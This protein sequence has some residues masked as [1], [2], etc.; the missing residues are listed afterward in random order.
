LFA[1]AAIAISAGAAL[2]AA[3]ASASAKAASASAT[4]LPMVLTPGSRQ[5]FA[6][7]PAEIDYTGDGTGVLGGFDGTGRYPSYGHLKWSSWTGTEALGSGAVWIDD[8]TPSCAAG[9]FS[10]YAIAVRAFD[11]AAGHFTRLRLRYR[12]RGAEVVDTRGV[13]MGIGG[14]YEY[15][16]VSVTRRKLRHGQ[17]F[18]VY[19]VYHT[20]ANGGCGL[21]LRTGPGYSHYASV[22]LLHD[23]D[24][25]KIVCQGVGEPVSGLNGT[26]SDVWD[27][28]TN[29]RWV[30]DYYVDTPGMEGA[31]SPPIPR[32]LTGPVYLTTA[33]DPTSNR[34]GQLTVACFPNPEPQREYVRAIHWSTFGGAKARGSG[35][36]Y[37]QSCLPSCSQSHL[38]RFRAHVLLGRPGYCSAWHVNVY[39]EGVVTANHTG[40]RRGVS[41]DPYCGAR[42]LPALTYKAQD[43]HAETLTPWQGG[44]VTVL[45]EPDTSRDPSVMGK[46][47]GALDRAWSYY[48]ESTGRAP[49]TDQYT[50]NGRD[51]IAEVS[52]DNPK[53]GGCGGAACTYF[54]KDGTEEVT[55][56]FEYGYNE[57]AQHD[58]YDQP[59]FYE[60]GRS[61]WFWRSQLAFK[62]PDQGDA[63]ETGFA[64][65]MRF[66]SMAAAGLSGAPFNG[67]TPFPTFESEVEGLSARYESNPSLTFS[68]TLAED[69]SPDPSFGGGTDFW[70]SLMMQLAAR[71]GGDTFVNR[72]WKVVNRQPAAT[73]TAGAVTNWEYAASYAACADL[74]SVFY[75]RWGFP[76]PDG[77]VTPRPAAATV[78]EPTGRCATG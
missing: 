57:I 59:L 13:R 27:K 63:V 58:L 30:A 3:A 23:G 18:Y 73:S 74:S 69:R 5:Q 48:A 16:I 9:K 39:T 53:T 70:A 46:L 6:L 19:R 56:Y 78:P 28:L 24:P 21:H 64:V 25:V 7:R 29:G 22:G 62:P 55:Q 40:W 52:S 76:R 75:T 45:L 32:C 26:S 35:T 1:L 42:E 20:C 12:Y 54:G 68:G 2:T 43:G 51:E 33:C 11:P 17:K 61:F 71:H 67:T 47:L 49:A 8:C 10:P 77:S 37:V 14:A 66:R 44:H 31:F 36:L 4:G 38:Y 60:L 72:F 34:P 41:L 65:W 50:L 15:F